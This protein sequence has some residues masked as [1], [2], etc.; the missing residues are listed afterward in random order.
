MVAAVGDMTG[1]EQQIRARIRREG[2]ITF[3]GFMDLALYG[4]GGFFASGRGAGRSG[5]DFVTSPETGSLY[6]ALV[7]NA[8]DREWRALGAPDPFFVIE[9]GAGNGRLAADVLRAR[10]DCAAALRYVLVERSESLRAE[11]RTRVELSAPELVAGP[12]LVGASGDDAPEPVERTGPLCAQLA[13]LPSIRVDGVVFANELLDNLPFGIAEFDGRQWHEVRV[14]VDENDRVTELLVPIAAPALFGAAPTAGTRL[15]IDRALTPWL[16]QAANTL[17]RGVVIVVDYLVPIAE[18]IE[19]SPK[20]LHTYAAHERGS[21]P[22]AQIGEVDITTDIAIEHLEAAAANAR[23]A[24]VSLDTQRDWLRGLG[25]ASLI[26]AA[27]DVWNE[28]ASIGDL[29]AMVA[30]SHINEAAALCDPTGLGDFRVA[31]LT[32]QGEAS[33][34]RK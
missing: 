18:I 28:R 7:A 11:Q 19:R 5:R 10:P 8:F 23:L 30:R 29:E 33:N 15:P 24:V 25:L 1:A 26:S 6:G 34:L 4:E 22:L 9:C 20:W 13:E 17:R 27:S 2:S 21:D 14:T 31:S 32:P 16:G 3:D 12:H